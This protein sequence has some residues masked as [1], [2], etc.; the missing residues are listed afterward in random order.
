MKKLLMGLFISLITTSVVHAQNMENRIAPHIV[1]ESISPAPITTKSSNQNISIPL[2][3]NKSFVIPK[4]DESI[5][6]SDVSEWVNWVK[7]DNFSIN[8][9]SIENCAFLPILEIKRNEYL[10]F[11]FKGVNYTKNNWLALPYS[12]N[13]KLWPISALLNGES[14]IIVERNNIPYIE[15]NEGNFELS[16]KYD[17]NL[18]NVKEVILPFTPVVYANYT[19]FNI[20]LK[21]S[22]LVID[23]EENNESQANTTIQVFRKLKDD[24]PLNLTTLIKIDYSG[25]SKEIELGKV[26]P[27]NF[28]LSKVTSNLKLSF[29][30][31]SYFVQVI[32]GTHLITLDAYSPTNIKSISTSGLIK[33]SGQ[34]I[35][36]VEFN[37]S[38]RQLKIEESSQ[39][40]PNQA[41]VPQN[42]SNLPA[43]L[44]EGKINLI[45]EKEGMKVNSPLELSN[46]KTSWYGFNGNIITTIDN[47]NTVNN[48][49]QILQIKTD[50]TKTQ[51]IKVNNIPQLII[52][53]DNYPTI[54]L[55]LGN[56]NIKTQY[57]SLI[58]DR[59][60]IFLFNGINSHNNWDMILAPRNR[61]LMGSGVER[62]DG[63]WKDSWNLYSL[64]F[65]FL[66][67][68]GVYKIIGKY[69]A[70]ICLLTIIFFQTTSI[71][72]WGAWLGVLIVM[73]ILNSI[74]DKYIEMKKYTRY[75]GLFLLGIMI[76]YSVPFIINEIKAIIN[77]S[78]DKISGYYDNLIGVADVLSL[79]AYLLGIGFFIKMINS[80]RE[81][82]EKGKR[83]IIKII[84][85]LLLSWF[86]LS[87]PTLLSNSKGSSFG[88][89]SSST[90]L[91]EMVSYS[92]TIPP[93]APSP[94]SPLE[95]VDSIRSAKMM[96][97]A[98]QM[99]QRAVVDEK[100]Q[101]GS[102]TPNWNFNNTVKIYPK[103]DENYIKM[104]V[105]S[106]L[107]VNIAGI[108]QILLLITL[109]YNFGIYMT[110]VYNKEKWLGK[111]PY[112]YINNLLTLDFIKNIKG[113]NHA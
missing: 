66:L 104:Y 80:F 102:G 24:I 86:F 25:I 54:I 101:V 17:N 110:Y 45:T 107:W 10:D 1:S 58:G 5:I 84:V 50:N 89:G 103:K 11:E 65:L 64:F 98:P 69:V 21:D 83:P 35:W 109:L 61:V 90:T 63:S 79:I 112:K 76:I 30:N 94:V 67:T 96:N 26:L 28:Y 59:I 72:A 56:L 52:E 48:D 13:K 8:C 33:D 43:W 100:V 4:V 93:N 12:K 62:I 78:L 20:S 34:E 73:G 92:P 14:A 99:S 47:V 49:N 111:F 113:D 81:R 39:V 53:K 97:K 55:P 71:F 106:P 16:I 23:S 74:P 15:V 18:K 85:M 6:P 105:A 41:N 77:P 108:I 29:R 38:L 57:Q 91:D 22:N 88:T 46:S 7:K 87:V 19:N 2:K 68:F 27:D 32:P 95:M 42:W 37:N 3:Q 9:P 40:D 82:N 31:G 70:V 44:V 60:P 51:F 75:L 36:S